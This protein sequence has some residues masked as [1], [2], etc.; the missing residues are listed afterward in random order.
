MEIS[1]DDCLRA[2]NTA[3]PQAELVMPAMDVCGQVATAFEGA[4]GQ[5]A[6]GHL[7]LLSFPGPGAGSPLFFFRIP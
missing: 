2:K 6:V 4:P 7:T 3:Q 5:A 1:E